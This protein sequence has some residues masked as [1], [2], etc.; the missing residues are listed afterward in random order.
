MS[1]QTGIWSYNSIKTVKATDVKITVKSLK[2][3]L[4]TIHNIVQE[5]ES[6][7]KQQE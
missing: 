7:Q 6:P 4:L 2:L 5:Y 1:L 3:T